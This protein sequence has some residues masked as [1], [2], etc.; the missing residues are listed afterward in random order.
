MSM[1]LMRRL[2]AV[3]IT[4]LVLG[5]VGWG[6]VWAT[7]MHRYHATLNEII[8]ATRADGYEITYD[9]ESTGGFPRRTTVSVTNLSWKS[10]EGITF[11][12]DAMDISSR[13]WVWRK[14]DA[15]FSHGAEITVPLEAAGDALKLGAVAGH[16]HIELN[17]DRL[18]QMGSLKLQQASFGRVPD[19][20]FVAGELN[21]DAQRPDQMPRSN[22]DAGLTLAAFASD[23]TIPNGVHTPFGGHMESADVSMQVMGATPDVRRKSDVAD[24]NK[25]SGVVSFD[26][27]NLKWG[28]LNVDAR[29]TMGFDDDLQPEGAFAATVFNYEPVMKALLDNGFIPEHQAS[30]LNAALSFFAKGNKASGKGGASSG[31]EF[32]IAVQLGG[33]F[34]GPVKVFAFPEIEWQVG[35]QLPK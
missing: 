10:P 34:F 27:L 25:K 22:A 16:A 13:M 29:G 23:V 4:V 7:A 15:S 2:I 17:A 1:T 35:D 28:V 20:V 6:A 32:P 31:V 3:C 9:G 11:H 21:A 18:W 5:G 24:W 14:F 30:M 19:Y 26:R 12:T 33:L 8:E